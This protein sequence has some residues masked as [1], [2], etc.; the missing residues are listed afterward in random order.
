MYQIQEIEPFQRY[1]LWSILNCCCVIELVTSWRASH[2]IYSTRE[3][4]TKTISCIAVVSRNTFKSLLELQE[5]NLS[6]F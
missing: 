2:E 1:P 3:T 5:C 4:W 6:L